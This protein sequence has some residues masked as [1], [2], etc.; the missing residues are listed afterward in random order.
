MS[1]SQSETAQIIWTILHKKQI[2]AYLQKKIFQ[3]ICSVVALSNVHFLNAICSG[4][5]GVQRLTD[6]HGQILKNYLIGCPSHITVFQYNFFFYLMPSSTQRFSRCLGTPHWVE[7]WM[8]LL[9]I[10]KRPVSLVC[11]NITI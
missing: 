2:S 4:S 10:D 9:R 11:D 8:C 5:S 3:T 7:R 1:H 6:T